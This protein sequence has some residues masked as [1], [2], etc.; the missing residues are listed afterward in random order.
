MGKIRPSELYNDLEVMKEFGFSVREY[1]DLHRWDR[2][3]L[4]YQM[5]MNSYF[6]LKESDKR[7]R[8]TDLK[9]EAIKNLPK[10]KLVG[11]HGH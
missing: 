8:E 11:K 2:K 4:K 3:L 10:T 6:A 1:H 5:Q 7:Q 9:N